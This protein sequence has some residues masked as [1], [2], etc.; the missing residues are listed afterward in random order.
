MKIM[1]SPYLDKPNKWSSH[2]QIIERLSVFSP[3]TRILD[4][5]TAT[6]TVG[7]MCRDTG[8]KFYGIEPNPQWAEKASPFYQ[9]IKI[10]SLETCPE[11]FLSQ[12][13][14]VVLG[15]VLEHMVSPQSVLERLLS[16]QPQGCLF[17]ISVPNIANLW[18]RLNLLFGKFDYTENGILDRTHLHFFTRKTLLKMITNLGLKIERISVTPIPLEKVSPFFETSP[19][20]QL[21]YHALKTFTDLFPTLLGYQFVVDTRKENT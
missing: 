4:I 12:Y 11:Q 8:L 15:D 19:L 5:G 16:L 20:G 10:A 6:G 2:S 21:I 18:I 7:R 14:A 3:G 17:I 9:D 13:Q 1:D